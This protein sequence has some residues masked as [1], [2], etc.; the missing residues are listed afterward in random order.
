M[1]EA[2]GWVQNVPQASSEGARLITISEPTVKLAGKGMA[3]SFKPRSQAD[4]DIIASYIPAPG[5]RPV[6]SSCRP[7]F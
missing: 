3:V 2:E 7:G 1:N 5:K 4:E 6:N